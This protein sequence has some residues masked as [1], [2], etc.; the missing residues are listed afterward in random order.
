MTA[1]RI[2]MIMQTQLQTIGGTESYLCNEETFDTF[3]AIRLNMEQMN[4]ID[5]ILLVQQNFY[6]MFILQLFVN[7]FQLTMNSLKLKLFTLNGRCVVLRISCDCMQCRG[8]V[9][10]KKCISCQARNRFDSQHSFHNKTVHQINFNRQLSAFTHIISNITMEHMLL[11][12]PPGT[13]D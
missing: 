5:M 10:C 13:C 6:S 7:G 11:I 9:R 3:I 2:V 1:L 12:V 8:G 4:Q